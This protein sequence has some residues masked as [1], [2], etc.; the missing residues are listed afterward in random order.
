MIQTHI[1]I[2]G[3]TQHIG[4]NHG[5]VK[6][7]ERL[8]VDGY[9]RGA[10]SRVYLHPWRADWRHVAEHLFLLQELRG[11]PL[12]IGVYAYSW[13]AG[14]GAI[15][16]ARELDKRG[17]RIRCMVLCDPVPRP[18]LPLRWLAMLP[19]SIGPRWTRTITVPANVDDVWNLYQRT[20]LP[21]GHPVAVVPDTV[22]HDDE[23][24]HCGHKYADDARQ[25]HAR[26]MDVA[27]RIADEAR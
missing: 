10:R 23:E 19:V 16:L 22:A 15:R 2:S 7:S 12:L 20:D 27:G 14:Y 8:H 3:F 18:I 21:Q 17:M 1:C 6:L 26:A 5:L 24:M 13:G 25:F 11:E 4:R 9:S